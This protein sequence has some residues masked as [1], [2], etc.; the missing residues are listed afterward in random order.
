MTLL[1][2][3]DIHSNYAAL[4]ALI[5]A[6]ENSA[7]P[8]MHAETWY[9][10]G[11][12]VGYYG[13]PQNSWEKILEKARGIR[14]GNHE[15]AVIA[16]NSERLRQLRLART[17]LL[18]A[19][20][21][22]VVL[23]QISGFWENFEE[24]C[25]L[26]N[27]EPCLEEMEGVKLVFVHADP[28]SEQ[29]PDGYAALGEYLYP[30]ATEKDPTYERVLQALRYLEA[31][32]PPPPGGKTIC[33][34]G[35]THTPMIAAL[36]NGRVYYHETDYTTEA[37]DKPFLLFDNPKLIDPK[38]KQEDTVLLINPGSVGQPRDGVKTKVSLK[39]KSMPHGHAVSYDPSARM[40]RFLRF[41]YDLQAVEECLLKTSEVL[42]GFT[43]SQYLWIRDNLRKTDTTTLGTRDRMVLQ[44][45][46]T[47]PIPISSEEIEEI[48]REENLLTNSGDIYMNRLKQSVNTLY[49]LDR[50]HLLDFLRTPEHFISSRANAY[51][52]SEDGFFRK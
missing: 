24:M 15:F 6:V 13:D 31:T 51:D 47:N 35:H 8:H 10:L 41:Q 25:Q 23:K 36:R 48:L 26:E 5:L 4:E 30:N 16:Q 37:E 38:T 9:C 7:N 20:I 46:Q 19:L 2:T 12:I 49:W 18:P 22:Q 50:Q 14:L 17:A 33:F 40:L 21:Q 43:D 52:Y 45:R 44:E 28:W 34:V 32:Y 11:D 39:G 3:S 1:I 29:G 27:Q 42:K